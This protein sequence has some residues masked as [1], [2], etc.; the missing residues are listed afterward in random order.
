MHQIQNLFFH[1]LES[2]R[3]IK[4][5][6][7]AKNA[8]SPSSDPTIIFTYASAG[9]NIPR[10]S[11]AGSCLHA[12]S[13]GA[14]SVYSRGR[15]KEEAKEEEMSGKDVFGSGRMGRQQGCGCYIVLAVVGV[16]FYSIP[17]INA[18]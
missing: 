4:P 11:Q 9:A 6:L 15:E 2:I 16:C 14:W 1:L 8:E 3:G 7:D 10:Q 18:Q 5:L 13:S 17:T 12:D